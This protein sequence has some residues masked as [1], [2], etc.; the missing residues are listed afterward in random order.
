MNAVVIDAANLL[1]GEEVLQAAVSELEADILPGS[2]QPSP[3]FVVLAAPDGGRHRAVAIVRDYLDGARFGVATSFHVF[4]YTTVRGRLRWRMARFHDYYNTL[5]SAVMWALRLLSSR[6]SA[7]RVQVVA[8]APGAGAGYRYRS[9][10]HV[11]AP[12]AM[13]GLVTEF[14]AM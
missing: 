2:H 14:A 12:A 8:A 11:A 6:T 4:L 1:R 9:T 5:A 13:R 10:Q 3:P 7:Q